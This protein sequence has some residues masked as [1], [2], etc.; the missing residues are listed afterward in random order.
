MKDDF[1]K[2]VDTQNACS[3]TNKNEFV[4]TRF[5]IEEEDLNKIPGTQITFKVVKTI[6]SLCLFDGEPFYVVD[7][8][9]IYSALSDQYQ[10]SYERKELAYA[11]V[12]KSLILNHGF[13][14]GNKRTAVIVLYLFSKMIGNDIKLSD[15]ELADLAYRIESGRDSGLSIEEIADRVF[16]HHESSCEVAKLSNI[17]ELA[18]DLI[19]KHEWLMF[20]LGKK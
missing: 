5:V 4:R 7:E 15:E 13:A 11:S 19:R 2:Q 16:S 12:F 3:V 6:N 9:K 17:E 8:R 14:S 18:K 1:K 10:P 20:E